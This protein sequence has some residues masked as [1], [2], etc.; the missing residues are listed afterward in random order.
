M[1]EP[2]HSSFAIQIGRAGA[3]ELEGDPRGETVLL[4]FEIIDSIAKRWKL[5]TEDD[6]MSGIT[7]SAWNF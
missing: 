7:L 5:H 4:T 3:G 6:F 1:L 2:R